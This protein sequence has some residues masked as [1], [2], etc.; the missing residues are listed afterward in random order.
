MAEIKITQLNSEKSADE[1]IDLKAKSAKDSPEFT[2]F[3]TVRGG[4]A[5]AVAKWSSFLA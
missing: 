5:F 2:A 3:T 1:I 4:V